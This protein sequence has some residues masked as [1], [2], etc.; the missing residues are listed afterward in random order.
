[1]VQSNIKVYGTEWCTD[2]HRSKSY[3]EQQKVPFEWIDVDQNPS[4]SEMSLK[5]SQFGKVEVEIV[6]CVP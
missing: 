1:M 6:Y 5:K 2:C 4:A 3:L